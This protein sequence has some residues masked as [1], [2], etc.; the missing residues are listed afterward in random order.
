MTFNMSSF[1]PGLPCSFPEESVPS[2]LARCQSMEAQISKL[3]EEAEASKKE[4]AAALEEVATANLK[5]QESEKEI[6]YLRTDLEG[7]EVYGKVKREEQNSLQSRIAELERDRD[8]K[9]PLVQVGVSVRLRY[10]EWAKKRLSGFK[11]SELD[12]PNIQRGNDAAHNAMGEVDVILFQG[13]IL[14]TTVKTSVTMPFTELYRST[15]GDYSSQPR[16]MLQVIN[17]EGTL[18]TLNVLNERSRP[19]ALKQLVLDQID[20]LKD[21]Y[22]KLSQES[23]EA[24]ED[25]KRRVTRV[26]ELTK[27]IID[28]E[29]DGRPDRLRGKPRSLYHIHLHD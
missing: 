2:L 24:D 9:E 15:P 13:D 26:I 23:F 7:L 14:P 18:R 8:L 4:K 28:E 3:N 22:G 17:C 12:Y 1:T 27:E 11:R 29:R 6:E 25:V 5:L 20:I 10:L 21:K 19:L 16:K